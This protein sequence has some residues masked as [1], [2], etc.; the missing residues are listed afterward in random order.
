M[1]EHVR[2]R[3]NAAWAFAGFAW[4][5]IL[6]V[7][8]IPVYLRSFGVRG[9]GL[10][11]IALALLGAGGVLHLGL[12]EATIKYVAMH[13]AR[14]EHREATRVVWGSLCIYACVGTLAAGSLWLISPWI[15]AGWFSLEGP[16]LRTGRTLFRVIALGL[17]ALI[18][19]QAVLGVFDGLQRFSVSQ[20]L[21]LLRATLQV[22]GG[23]IAATSGAGVVG[24]A[25]VYVSGLWGTW[26]L[27]LALGIARL[28]TVRPSEIRLVATAKKLFSF[29][30]Y[31]SLT[32]LGH[33][34]V[35]Q[36]DKVVIGS[37][38]GVEAVSFYAVPQSIAFKIGALC[39]SV[40]R[41]LLP[42]FS[43]RHKGTTG[44]RLAKPLFD[45]WR[46]L[47]LLALTVAS[48][49]YA[50]SPWLLSVWAGP[51]VAAKSLPVYW[52]L[53]AVYTLSAI[54]YVVPHNYLS[55]V[56]RPDI[57]ARNTMVVG[58][59]T[60][61][62]QA[63]LAYFFG[64]LGGAVGALLYPL[65]QLPLIYVVVV[66]MET[67]S[68]GELLRGLPT[69]VLAALV[70]TVLAALG[71]FIASTR[72]GGHG[73]GLALSLVLSGLLVGLAGL[74]L[75]RRRRNVFGSALSSVLPSIGR[76]SP[77]A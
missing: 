23:I 60:L 41:V 32:S 4:P 15:A 1:V 53:I 13:W 54:I 48:G 50:T 66:T 76:K 28:P 12:G 18:S 17:P 2:L 55:A 73:A 58:L 30:V 5:T 34:A 11:S 3:Q 16:E 51:E 19:M 64:V 43:S 77:R 57:L 74:A 47:I 10:W 26:L 44:A 63:F 70:A 8:A 21:V 71:G 39:H 40:S 46:L 38:V 24:V 56:G 22:G 75:K 25:I 42:F 62:V 14:S 29:G 6:M 67:E 35:Q 31:S 45:S 61:V 68:P 37:V 72:V 9:F 7:V 69:P 49:A 52:I 33:M 27:G 20:S 36:L 65:G 59:L